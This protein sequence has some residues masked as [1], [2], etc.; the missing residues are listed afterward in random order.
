MADG[1]D[2][3]VRSLTASLFVPNLLFSIGQGAVGP[4]AAL[5][6]LDLGATPAVAGL[7]VACRGLGTIL[8]D[9]PAGSIVARFG[10]KRSM[11]GS[12]LALTIVSLAIAGA[13][14]LWAFA[15]LIFLMGSTW[16]IWILA[17]VSLATGAAPTNYRG[18][19]M[20]TVGGMHR[21]GLLL[22]PLL[23]GAVITRGSMASPFLLMAILSLMAS[24]IVAW[25]RIGTFQI[26]PEN[27]QTFRSVVRA[28]RKLLGPAGFVAVSAQILRS[29]RETILPLWGD[30]LGI[31]ATTILAVF[32]ASAAIESI[33]FYPV[34]RLMDRKGRKWA[35]IPALGIFS[36][37]LA[38]LPLSS[39]LESF[40]AVAMMM[41]L[42]NG[43]STGLNMTLG[44]DLSPL[45][46][47]SRFLAVWR[48]VTDLGTTSGP[49]IVAFAISIAGLGTAAVSV[50][51]VG[52]GGALVLWRRVPETLQPDQA[53]D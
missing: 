3:R 31:A 33:L 50:A 34:G 23:A 45:L 8:T 13:P 44:S 2:F 16:S 18:R 41:G 47:R 17:R 40:V 26:E 22:G 21:I 10:E 24:G 4:L 6:A 30:H 1:G 27:T 28:S 49:M 11:V 42:A 36:V 25:A 39:D 5:L 7:I 12:G 20:S 51:A 29:T 46:G 14:P 37:S 43:M 35:G 52:A 9:I 48:L 38:L 19:V 53:S 32:S 15:V